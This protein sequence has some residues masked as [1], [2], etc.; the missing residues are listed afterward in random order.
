MMNDR[1]GFPPAL[2]VALQVLGASAGIVG[3]LTFV[4]GTLLWL[5]FSELHLPA[6]QSVARLP[7]ELLLVA[8]AH[9]L[10]GPILIGLAVLLFLVLI[11]P[12]DSQ[13]RLRLRFWILLPLLAIGAL[14]VVTVGIWDLDL[15]PEQFVM[16]VAT[17]LAI[18]LVMLTAV[19]VTRMRYVAWVVFAAFVVCGAV[20]AVVQTSGKP[21]ME[22]IAMLLNDGKGLS[23]FYVGETGDRIFF[24]PLPGSGD[25]GDPFADADIDRIISFSRDKVSRVAMRE[26]VGIRAEEAGREQAQSLLADLQV[27]QA[28]GTPASQKQRVTTLNPV[29]AFAPLVNLHSREKAWPMSVNSFL[30][31][32]SLVWVHDDGC[33]DYAF[34]RLDHVDD[35]T[36]HREF[37]GRFDREKLGL[38]LTSRKPGP[39]T[40]YLHA[41]ATSSCR[42]QTQNGFL[43]TEHTRPFDK[44]RPQGLPAK[45]GFSLDLWDKKRG[46]DKRIDDSGPQSL[47][48]DVPVYFERH[49]EQVDGKEGERITYWFFYGLS[50]PPGPDLFTNRVVHEGDWERISVLLRHAGADTYVPDSV[51]YHYHDSK[52]NLPWYAVKRVGAGGPELATHPVV[53][54]A[55]GSHASYPRAGRYENVFRFAGRRRFAVSDEAIGCP[56]CP[57]WQTWELLEDARSQP[58]YGFGGAWGEV[59]GIGGTTGPLG[60]SRYKIKGLETQPE[61]RVDGHRPVAT[62]G[63]NVEERV[64]ER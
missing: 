37:L 45:E 12:L 41:P 38:S 11:A 50:Q 64:L 23:G 19:S 3:F 40:A 36:E 17:L 8:G 2:G 62:G 35:R 53:F 13:G 33:P 5:R 32:S 42:D 58:W 63:G 47:L 61:Q 6:D 1:N 56:K 28:T 49:P 7:K 46:G 44:E 31:N 43:S 30:E 4:G 20:L 51:L 48:R 9:A 26:P 59:G 21:R 52:R 54:S 39:L 55:V 16:G 18:A 14:I 15:W 34:A 29:T 57:Q 22:P 27:Q 25:P 60:P 10:L 24:A